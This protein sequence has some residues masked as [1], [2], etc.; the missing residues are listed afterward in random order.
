MGVE[1]SSGQLNRLL[2][3]GYDDFHQEKDAIKAVGL[4]VSSYVQ[5]DDTGARHQGQNGYCTY[6][7][8]EWF[9][10]FAST[11][12]KSRINFLEVLQ[13]ERRYEINAEALAYMA[14]HG[15]AAGHRERLAQR[16]I[17]ATDPKRGP[18]ICGGT[19]SIAPGDDPRHGR[20]AHRRAGRA[21]VSAGSALAQR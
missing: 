3:E 13:T 1:I 5:T 21:G 19:G 2:T 20:R 12:A 10:C 11:D 18:P 17:V 15:V 16:P 6:L 4:T 7:G 9:A 8:N 14:D